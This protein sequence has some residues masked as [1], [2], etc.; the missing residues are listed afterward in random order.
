MKFISL[1]ILRGKCDRESVEQKDRKKWMW[2]KIAV[3]Q[4]L[5]GPALVFPQMYLIRKRCQRH[6]KEKPMEE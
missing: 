1:N 5:R 3:K 2:A 6:L 4:R